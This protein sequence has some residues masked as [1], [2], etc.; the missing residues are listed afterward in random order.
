M[1]ATNAQDLAERIFS[2][3]EVR[4]LASS[5]IR[6]ALK[7]EVKRDALY[8]YDEVVTLTGVSYSTVKRAVEAERLKADYIG[9]EPRIRGAAIFQWLDEGGRTGRTR[10]D[11]IKEAA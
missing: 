9:S 10:R 7:P 4:E 8:T 6:L 1:K 11:L 2:S 3:D 5:L